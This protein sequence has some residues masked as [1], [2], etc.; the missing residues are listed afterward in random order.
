MRSPR[1]LLA[2][3]VLLTFSGCGR[4]MLP[5]AVRD[6]ATPFAPV[7][8]FRA[9]AVPTNNSQPR[10]IALGADG[11]EWFT[12]SNQGAAKVGRVDAKG[13]ITEFAVPNTGAGTDD[14]TL[15]PDGAL[16]F[17][18]PSGFPDFFVGRV[19]TDG[20]FTGFSPDCD[21]LAGCSIVPN[22]ITTGPDGNLWFTESLRNSVVRLTPAGVF[23]FFVLP[24]AG[25]NP[26]GIASGSDGNLWFTE[27]NANQIA[28][29]NP[30]TGAV[31]EFGGV[32]GSPNRIT[33]G[34]DG[35]LW[36]TEP[37]PFDNRI[38][39]ITTAGVVTEF[40]LANNAQP[41]DIVA[42][43]D[44]NLWFT[45]YFAGQLAK[46]T[47]TGVVTEVQAVKGGPWGIGRGS[48]GM[49]WMTVFDGNRVGRFTL[50]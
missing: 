12:E 36:F 47:P 28:R 31:T 13:K 5:T 37:F 49:I 29:V 44:G 46:I 15:G 8:R 43:P 19:T 40:Q 4:S 42:G 34:P 1:L 25:A 21:P 30:T 41:R 24:T 3:L 27:S 39:R 23:T 35:N 10:H 48:D 7:D 33:A 20:V 50:L 14:I 9:F 16:W 45:E 2:S 22:G 38:G 17:T 18:G 32:T 26:G 11:L 6:G